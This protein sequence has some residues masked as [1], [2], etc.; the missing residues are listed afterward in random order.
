MF[1]D[2]NEVVKCLTLVLRPWIFGKIS[3]D[4]VIEIDVGL[5]THR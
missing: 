4:P 5:S 2:R 3:L 1:I